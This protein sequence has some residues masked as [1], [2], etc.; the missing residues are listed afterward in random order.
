[1]LAIIGGSGLSQIDRLSPV[2][3]EQVMTPWDS[4]AVDVQFFAR[5]EQ[6]IAF[7]ARHG[8]D[9]AIPPHRINYRANLWALKELG[10]KQVIGINI[11][12]GIHQRM[13]PGAYIVPDQI[14]DYTHSRAG[15]FFEDDLE[16]VTHIDFS[17]PFSESMRQDLLQ[18]VEVLLARETKETTLLG[19]GVYGCTQGPRLETAAEI[20]RL[21]RDGCD[22]VGMTAMPEV[23]LA[24][25]LDIDYA[26]LALSVNWAAGL[27]ES[28]ITLDEIGVV[29]RDGMVLVAD[30]IDGLLE[31]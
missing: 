19:R 30:L 9:S 26:M 13:C 20:Q 16:Q 14:I 27:T 3:S 15:S 18:R 25:E 12:G 23:A 28:V 4:Q 21:K 7:L 31:D 24:R 11:V 2:R 1:M 6:H 10:V 8:S 17:F 5:G 22:I 29:V